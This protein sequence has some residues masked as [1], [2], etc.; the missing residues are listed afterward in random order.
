MNKEVQTTVTYT[1][2]FDAIK[3]V[4]ERGL[5]YWSARDLQEPLGYEKWQNFEE[6]I[7][8][9]MISCRNSGHEPSEQFT[10]VSKLQK[11]G[12]RGG[13]QEQKDY[14]LT[15]FACYLT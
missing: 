14:H 7:E 2:P 6:A 15:R 8:R 12:N 13:T 9:A 3:R 5:E 4:N 1:S 10:D 11:R